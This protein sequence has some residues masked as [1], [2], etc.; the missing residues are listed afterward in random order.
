MT[1]DLLYG[2]LDVCALSLIIS[3]LVAFGLSFLRVGKKSRTRINYIGSQRHE[4][5]T[6]RR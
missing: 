2:F 1:H 6:R 3:S 4:V 5:G